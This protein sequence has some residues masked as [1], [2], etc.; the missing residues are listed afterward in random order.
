MPRPS[1]SL[2]V[3]M[4]SADTVLSSPSSTLSVT[5]P[6]KPCTVVVSGPPEASPPPSTMVLAAL[7]TAVDVNVAPVS[8]SMPSSP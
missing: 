6:P 4:V 7:M 3:S 8:A 1:V 5:S 2:G